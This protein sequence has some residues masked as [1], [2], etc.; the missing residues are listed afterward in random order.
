MSFSVV[1]FKS[2]IE[3]YPT[4]ETLSAFLTSPEGGSLRIC[5]DFQ[6]APYVVI[7]YVKGKSDFSKPWVRDARSIVWDTQLNRAVCMAPVKSE[8]TS[9]IPNELNVRVSEFV[10]GTMINAFKPVSGPTLLTTRSVVNSRMYFYDHYSTNPLAYSDMF[11]EALPGWQDLLD[12]ILQPYEFV[13]FVIQHPHNRIV[14]PIKTP[15]IFVTYTGKANHD[16]TF[17]MHSNPLDWNE[18]LRK[19]APK[20]YTQPFSLPALAKEN[21]YSWQGLVLQDTTSSKRWKLRNKFYSFVRTLR[22]TESSGFLIFLRLRKSGE[23]KNY[24][25]YYPEESNLFWRFEQLL[26][27]TTNTLFT[28]YVN[29]NKLKTH[30]M[31]DFPIQLRTHVYALHGLYVTSLPQKPTAENPNPPITYT[32]PITI[33]REFVIEYV[34]RLSVEDQRSL[35]R[36]TLQEPKYKMN[37]VEPK[38]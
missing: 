32:K 8:I 28:C 17:T 22:G 12:T 25:K 19:Y 34:N 14:T 6:P 35:I 10:D 23:M 13:S 27:E 21:G 31:K 1:S 24:L 18:K 5:T 30:T 26:R 33:N 11:D 15:R 38:K 7:R 20:T 37:Y 36:Y 3:T 4:W 2:L 9:D 16:G 29:K